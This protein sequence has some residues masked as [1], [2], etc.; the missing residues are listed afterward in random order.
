MKKGI[1]IPL[2]FIVCGVNAQSFEWTEQTSN[3]SE[4][5]K[6]VDFVNSTNGWAVG[7]NG[8]LI[9]TSDGGV[10]WESQTSGTTASLRAV[11]FVDEL[12][13]WASGESGTFLRTIDGGDTWEEIAIPGF[14]SLVD[15][16]S[17]YD[18]NI[19]YFVSFGD[20]WSTD[21]GGLTWNE[22]SYNQTQT[23]VW[24][25][26]IATPT[27]STAFIAG[28]SNRTSATDAT[29]FDNI[30]GGSGNFVADGVNDFDADDQLYS[31]EFTDYKTGYAGG[32]KG[33]LYKMA[34]DGINYNGLW[35]LNFETDSVQS[36][37][38]SISFSSMDHGIFNVNSDDASDTYVFFT[39][40][41]GDDWSIPDTIADFRSRKLIY[42]ELG[43]AWV[44]G[45]YGK[46]YKGE[47]ITTSVTEIEMSKLDVWPNPFNENLEISFAD[48]TLSSNARIGIFNSLG[49][50]LFTKNI[51][52]S[53]TKIRIGD[54][55]DLKS[56]IYFIRIY[57]GEKEIATKKILKQ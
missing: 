31:I 52:P 15:D 55:G 56:G 25:R 2:I 49:Q 28:K 21:D 39:Q 32:R 35:E 4:H 54:L 9:N 53:S 23:Q 46:I 14:I 43:N 13:G 51:N 22:E 50:E 36:F 7:E 19:G 42:P 5:L 57:D 18:S 44:V 12:N 30:T 33:K 6:D 11:D 3:T 45:D 1:L 40:N 8:T 27:D 47:L 38:Y 29:V 10:T 48:F 24:N 20:I 37:I 16:I 17:F 41:A 26:G 34:G